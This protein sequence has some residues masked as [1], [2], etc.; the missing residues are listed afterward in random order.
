MVGYD[1]YSKGYKLFD[2]SSE[3]KFIERSVQVEED[4]MQET[5]LAHGECSHHP[6][7][8]DVSDESFSDFFDFDIYD[9]VDEIYLDH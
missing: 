5:E 2:P 8:D 3:K 4:L 7:H 9:D 6:L 1:E